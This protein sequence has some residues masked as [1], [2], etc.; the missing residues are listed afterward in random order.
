MVFATIGLVGIA[1]GILLISCSELELP[2]FSRGWSD[3]SISGLLGS[4]DDLGSS[5]MVFATL[6]LVV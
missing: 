3:F 4:S 6:D 2:D 1:V 5:S